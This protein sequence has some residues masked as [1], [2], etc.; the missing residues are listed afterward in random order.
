[1]LV[2]IA[3]VEEDRS[4]ALRL[5]EFLRDRKIE[6]WT[7]AADLLAGE[8]RAAAHQ[9][10][11]RKAD[12]CLVL[13]TP[14]FLRRRRS[15]QYQIGQILRRRDH[16]LREDIFII[17]ALLQPC[18]IP[19][20]LEDFFPVHLF[21]SDGHAR[22]LRALR[23]GAER[24]G[25]SAAAQTSALPESYN[26]PPV[27]RSVSALERGALLAAAHQAI[28]SDEPEAER[29]LAE[30]IVGELLFL[31]ER[32]RAEDR[33]EKDVQ[34]KA[35]SHASAAGLDAPALVIESAYVALSPAERR[36]AQSALS[37]ISADGRTVAASAR[38]RRRWNV[39][40]DLIVLHLIVGQRTEQPTDFDTLAAALQ[41]VSNA[42]S[43][44]R[45]PA[46]ESALLES[47]FRPDRFPGLPPRSLRIHR[48]ALTAADGEGVAAPDWLTGA[49]YVCIK[50]RIRTPGLTAQSLQEHA[51]ITAFTLFGRS[52]MIVALLP[53]GELVLYAGPAVDLKAW[54]G[55]HRLL[56]NGR[57]RLDVIPTPGPA[58]ARP[59]S[60]G[61]DD[62]GAVIRAAIRLS[63]E[64]AA[65]TA[66]A[67]EDKEEYANVISPSLAADYR[68]ANREFSGFAQSLVSVLTDDYDLR[69]ALQTPLDS[70]RLFLHP[71]Q[72]ELVYSPAPILFV[73]GG[74][75]T[76]KTVVL[77]HRI[78]A[79][80][81]RRSR[82]LRPFCIVF[83]AFTEAVAQNM[84][85]MLASLDSEC[86]QNTVILDARALLNR[87]PLQRAYFSTDPRDKT[88]YYSISKSE[89]SNARRVTDLF[90]DEFQDFPASGA[91]NFLVRL[92]L[93][94]R[95]SGAPIT[96]TYDEHQIIY[97]R[98]NDIERWRSILGEVQSET[99]TYC[100]RLAREISEI[101]FRHRRIALKYAEDMIRLGINR[102]LK[103]QADPTEPV[104]AFS[105]G[106]LTLRPCS[107]RTMGQTALEIAGELSK[108]YQPGEAALVY[109]DPGLPGFLWLQTQSSA[110]QR[111]LKDAGF[112]CYNGLAV[113][114]LEFR[115]G[116]ILFPHICF[117]RYYRYIVHGSLYRNLTELC[118][119]LQYFI[120]RYVRGAGPYSLRSAAYNAAAMLALGRY[121]ALRSRDEP[122]YQQLNELIEKVEPPVR[123]VAKRLGELI[124]PATRR[125][126]ELDIQIADH[127][128]AA[129]LL[130]KLQ[131]DLSEVKNHCAARQRQIL[132][133][134]IDDSLRDINQFYV[135]ITRFRERAILVY[136]QQYPLERILPGALTEPAPP[137]PVAPAGR[138]KQ[139][140]Q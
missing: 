8:T 92:L 98:D 15:I 116:V 94:A 29:W 78:A 7:E 117:G 120:T 25:L 83:I 114:G 68:R 44:R 118:D 35:R 86:L 80:A 102:M 103:L 110:V 133:R 56:T 100:Y 137:P 47:F 105:G 140:P 30:A 12:F 38:A 89:G 13:I 112:P 32:S 46:L 99:L 23:R 45:Y 67:P 19:A 129:D 4:S 126:L 106:S 81:Y 125:D 87:D 31:G 82:E 115:A 52:T 26:S 9:D 79:A 40:V 57:D 93:A 65:Q 111:K 122:Y 131:E 11:I 58:G 14:D 21:E 71:R 64:D 138:R 42:T 39:F 70:W 113:K 3:C 77:A 135:A 107:G 43:E 134:G 41:V 72:R 132:R 61:P 34:D 20:E 63:G 130:D 91:N 123:P 73:Q 75:G 49:L 54:F 127:P 62:A 104:Y 76:G 60:L 5:R 85:A 96:C 97:A 1:M 88:L 2:Y 109:I 37:L 108:A 95:E 17:P 22:L 27:V 50:H 136:D 84:R 55:R 139:A 6:A 16:L 18:E 59:V 69:R 74:P 28:E 51:R 101:A 119:L 24:R 124:R 53:A 66:I 128:R 10:A 121:D 48:T 90:F 36:L 33:R